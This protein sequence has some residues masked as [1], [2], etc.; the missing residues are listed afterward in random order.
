MS[1]SLVGTRANVAGRFNLIACRVTPTL[2]TGRGKAI[3]FSP[4][5]REG[6]AKGET[7]APRTGKTANGGPWRDAADLDSK[8]A[9]CQSR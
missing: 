8:V 1:E 5:N 3:S 6:D 4:N 2:V 7:E 9:T